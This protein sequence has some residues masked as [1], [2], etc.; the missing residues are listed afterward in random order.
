MILYDM[1]QAVRSI[2]RNLVFS[3]IIILSLS[4]GLLFPIVNMASVY[5]TYK[6]VTAQFY[7]G[8]NYYWAKTNNKEK[9]RDV[10]EYLT[11][12]EKIRNINGVEA[13]G[14]QGNTAF[15]VM[16]QSSFVEMPV[17]WV[18]KDILKFEGIPNNIIEELFS[19]DNKI[20][21]PLA[22]A[23]EL[24]PNGKN[25]TR[26]YIEIEDKK[27][28]VI[29]VYQGFSSKFLASIPLNDRSNIQELVVKFSSNDEGTLYKINK[30][31]K[32]SKLFQEL[33]SYDSYK[34]NKLENEYAKYAFSMGLCIFLLIF[35]LLNTISI[36]A[37]KYERDYQKWGIL[38][39]FGASKNNLSIQ[40]Y[41]ETILYSLL[42]LLPVV[43]GLVLA[44]YILGELGIY[45]EFSPQVFVGVFLIVLLTSLLFGWLSLRK[46]KK[47]NLLKALLG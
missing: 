17:R 5:H 42:S 43:P 10:R 24:F 18:T 38:H 44:K 41:T 45:I 6:A 29:S 13:V 3:I 39:T 11:L 31:I 7:V 34:Y 16:S 1:L 25:L 23:N 19:K 14:I 4:I 26:S 40:V 28:Q 20:I 37:Y 15:N 27:Y 22:R 35:S 2:R 33:K 9:N 8:E 46:I 30:L 32:E 36:L 12:L 21:L 47:S